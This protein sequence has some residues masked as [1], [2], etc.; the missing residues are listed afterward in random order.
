[1]THQINRQKKPLSAFG[2]LGPGD[3]AYCHSCQRGDPPTEPFKGS[4]CKRCAEA[5]K[6]FD[7]ARL[8]PEPLPFGSTL[9]YTV[10]HLLPRNNK[11][12]YTAQTRGDNRLIGWFVLPPFQRP[13]VWSEAQKV[14]LIES[15]WIG[16][17]IGAYFLNKPNSYNDPT[18][19]WLI[20]GQQRI[21]AILEYLD[22]KFPVFGYRWSELPEHEQFSFMNTTFPCIETRNSDPAVLEDLYN[23]L[24]YGGTPHE[25][26]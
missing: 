4:R 17:P 24:A 18:D 5:V 25:P 8:M 9:N 21:T 26:R 6:A 7:D 1:M 11:T 22:D 13:P 15:M 14:K 12:D 10:E 19:L 16:L 23:R 20:D 3:K 2:Y